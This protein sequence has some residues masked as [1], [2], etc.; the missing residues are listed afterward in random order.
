MRAKSSCTCP[1]YQD[2][3]LWCKHLVATAL[4]IVA[5]AAAAPARMAAAAPRPFQLLGLFADPQSAATGW[6]TRVVIPAMIQAQG[7]P[8]T[9]PAPG[10]QPRRRALRSA[11]SCA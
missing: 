2:M 8:A 10:R 9:P 5:A 4:A 1:A 3:G 6:V 11:P 7:R